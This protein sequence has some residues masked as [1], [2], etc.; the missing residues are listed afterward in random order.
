M[1]NQ[2]EHSESDPN[3]HTKFIV[4]TIIYFSFVFLLVTIAFFV[5][6]GI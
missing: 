2:A 3:D 6:I 1:L 5:A 4:K